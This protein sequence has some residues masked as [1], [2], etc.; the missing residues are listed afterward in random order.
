MEPQQ[1][2]S[3][4]N[5]QPPAQLQPTPQS[6]VQQ[7]KKSG[8]KKA[9]IIVGSIIVGFLV[10]WLILRLVVQVT[11]GSTGVGSDPTSNLFYDTLQ[12]AAQQ[13]RVRMA[14]YQVQYKSTD[15]QKANKINSLDESLAELDTKSK[16]YSS[17]FVY[18]DSFSPLAERC[19]KNQI[20]TFKTYDVTSFQQAEDALKQPAHPAIADPSDSQFGPCLYTSRFRP[21]KVT[22]GIIP[23]GFT[24]Q[25]AES[26]I[27]ALKNIN[28][29][30]L[31]DEGTTT[32]KGKTGHKI[33]FTLNQVQGSQGTTDLFFYA[34]RDGTSKTTGANN[35]DPMH[36]DR[37]LDPG[38]GTNLSGFYIIDE[39][40]KLPMYSEFN[41]GSVP[42][43]DYQPLSTKQNY[44]FNAD[45]T[46]T[47]TTL[48][49]KL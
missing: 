49:E 42:D 16:Q 31:K 43:I 19:V 46:I 22:D 8:G 29:L 24:A 39:A 18:G 48:L 44:T 15:D 10:L 32:Y 36:F 12:N 45:F 23:L 14:H 1:T 9:L 3:S 35:K 4:Q 6:P 37:I 13:T 25:Q 28:L 17:V 21:G 2:L 27:T 34:Q 26:W 5:Q 38:S 47:Q 40:K 41:S 20:Y 33:S 7:P 11:M 30:H